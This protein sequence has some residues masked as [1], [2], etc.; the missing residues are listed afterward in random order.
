MSC[1]SI[2]HY[3]I[4]NACTRREG[5]VERRALVIELPCRKKSLVEWVT[6]EKDLVKDMPR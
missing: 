1:A 2:T 6:E 4:N 3:V 5:A